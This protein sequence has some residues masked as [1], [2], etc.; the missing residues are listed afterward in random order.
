[1]SSLIIKNGFVY[2]PLN[3]INGEVKDILIENGKVVAKI[4]DEKKA[5]VID[6]TNKTVMPGGVDSHSHIAGAKVNTGRIMRPEDS[7]LHTVAKTKLTYSG[8]GQTVPS[9]YITGYEYAAMGYTT[10]MEAAMP[11]L[12]ALHT[13]EEMFHI[14]IIDK[15]AYEV[16]GNNW[17]VMK[18]LKE[19]NLEKCAAYVAWLLKRTKGY[20]IKIV[21]P[22]GVEQWKW[23]KN[24]QSLDEKIDNFDISSREIIDG[25]CKVNEM[26]ELPMSIHLHANNLGKPGNHE[27]TRDSLK[28]TG[29]IK[30]N[31]GG[32]NGSKRKQN[33]YLAHAQFNSF[34]G[35]G[36]ADFASGSKSVTDYVNANDHVV[37]DL[38]AV[39]FGNATVMTGDGPAIHY[40][41]KLTGGKWSNKDIELECGSG[42]IPFEYLTTKPIHCIQWAIGLELA[43][44]VNDLNKVIMTTDHPN[45]GPFSKYPKLIAWLM[46]SK[47]R[48]DTAEM[49]HKSGV[50]KTRITSTDR[51]LSLY[52]IAMVTRAT[53]ARTIGLAGRKGHLGVG[54][55]GDVSVYDINPKEFDSSDYRKIEEKFSRASYT[56]KDGEVIAED[57]VIKQVNSGRTFWVDRTFDEAVEKEVI[58]DVKENFR[59]YTVNF[60]NYGVDMRYLTRPT[61]V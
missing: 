16:F 44:Y 57:G 41:H 59:Y 10:V 43:L 38:G 6:A 47:A 33:L 19:G 39:P 5:K 34:E 3:K 51:E 46:S 17:F 31:S 50:E 14:P 49:I 28:I 7:R 35:T 4:S 8:T 32:E 15:G 61:S 12:E 48:K 13:H 2:D 58:K 45:G 26:L 42:V 40:I 52:D 22:A 1:M 9:V 36:W 23:G 25:L 37:L 20:G 56:I 18:Y 30:V 55:D 27:I 21:N 11:P 53:P 54:A 29:N 60:D 24:V